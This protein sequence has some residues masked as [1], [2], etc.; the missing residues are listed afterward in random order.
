MSSVIDPCLLMCT[1]ER[2]TAIVMVYI[3]DSCAIGDDA[4]LESLHEEL[5][6]YFVL[7]DPEELKDYLGVMI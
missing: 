6:E 3:D 4:S 1:D 2:G 7:K 5:A